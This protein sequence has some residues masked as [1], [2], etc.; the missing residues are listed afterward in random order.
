ML[1]RLLLFSV[2]VSLGL[3][4][5]PAHAGRA[6]ACKA[7]PFS[8]PKE[9]QRAVDAAI[10]ARVV[11]TGAGGVSS[12]V[13][14]RTDYETTTLSQ[15]AAARSWVEYTL[16]L[17]LAKKLISQDL[18]DELLR[19]LIAP[20]VTTGL[21]A[22]TTSATAAPVLAPDA[23]ADEAS[24]L[25]TVDLV[26]TWQVVSRF[27]WSTCP[28]PNDAPGDFAYVWI[29]GADERGLLRVD[30]SGT[31]AFPRMSGEPRGDHLLLTGLRGGDASPKS[32]W[33]FAH[34]SGDSSSLYGGSTVDLRLMQGELVGIRDV[35][36]YRERVIAAEADGGVGVNLVPCTVRFAVRATR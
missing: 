24:S 18:H 2:L 9:T 6:S 7:P 12:T 29:V 3:A 19:S 15:D 32:D 21:V 31:T 33:T 14:T 17:K 28:A 34:P 1:S 13:E 27:Q 22:E 36:M 8:V 5:V 23:P 4:S 35:V 26:G 30:V 10:D 20:A 16:C 25:N 11:G